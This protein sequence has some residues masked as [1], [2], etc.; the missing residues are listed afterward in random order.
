M[1]DAMFMYVWFVFLISSNLSDHEEAGDRDEALA[2][3][4][5]MMVGSSR[6]SLRET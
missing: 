2:L 6:E 3:S 4:M 5:G 1:N